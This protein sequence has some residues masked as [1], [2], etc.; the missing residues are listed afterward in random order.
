MQ[1]ILASVVTRDR[2]KS[3][4]NV[5]LL[6]TQQSLKPTKLL[7]VDNASGPETQQLIEQ[8]RARFDWI[9]AVN[10]GRNAGSGGGQKVAME[11]AVKKGFD[12]LYTMDDDCEPAPDALEKIVAKWES[13]PDREQWALNSTVKAKGADSLSFVLFI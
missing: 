9:T 6:L 13:L 1:Q 5:L 7:I 12:L 10:T 8:W 11:Y 3:L 4:A 2:P